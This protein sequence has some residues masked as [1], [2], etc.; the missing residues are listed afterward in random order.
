MA[1]KQSKSSA[2]SVA[3]LAA[4]L[5]LGLGAVAVAGN[6]LLQQTTTTPPPPAAPRRAA[7]VVGVAALGRIEP[8]GEVVHLSFPTS[9]DGTRIGQ[10]LVREG[11]WLD[12]GQVVAVLN[13]R[14]RRAAALEQARRDVQV[15]RARLAQVRAGAK[16][17]DLDAQRAEITR[18]RAERSN[19]LIEERR[20]ATLF[21]QGALSASQRDSKR[22]VLE[23][24][25]A[26]LSQA[27]AGL[28]SIAEVRPVDVALAAAE[29]ERA[30]AAAVTAERDLELTYIRA[31]RSGRVLKVHARPGEVPGS[32]GVADLGDT[33]AMYVVAE[34]Y[35]TDVEKVHPGQP[36]KITGDA[37]SGTLSGRVARIGLQVSRQRIFDVNPLAD[38]D[39]KVVEVRV[40]LD[41]QASRRVSGLTN[42][43]VQVVIDV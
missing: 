39:R 38:M 27:E 40:R 29:V 19:A 12:A 33:R 35:E 30:L 31:P 5:A 11:Q 37:F 22:L 16:I 20:A 9:I 14:D 36:V 7:P 17:G 1:L 18:L 6:F 32:N 3:T 34:V 10:I 26:Q 4:G 15:A 28:G 24:V 8:E 13:T 25:E 21:R 42:L 41:P 2:G 23:S 43:Q